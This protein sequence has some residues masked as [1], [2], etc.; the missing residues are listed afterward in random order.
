M[1][2]LLSLL[3][4]VLVVI[5]RYPLAIIAVLFFSSK[6]KLTLTRWTWLECID[7][8]LIGDSGWR[9]VHLW[10]TDP[11]AWYNRVRWL[12]RNGGNRVCYTVLGVP[13]DPVWRMSQASK[14]GFHVRKDGAWCFR[15]FIPLLVTRRYLELFFGWALFGP[16]GGRCKFVFTIRL[17]ESIG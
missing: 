12:W 15:V 10:G 14:L 13:D 2:W 9:E 1:I 3:F 7:N 5:A 16:N 6:D 8:L 11:Y 4:Q 17:P